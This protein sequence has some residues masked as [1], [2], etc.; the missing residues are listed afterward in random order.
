MPQMAL[1]RVWLP[2]PN[3]SSRG[4]TK[5]RL[6]VLHTTE[7][8]Q[9]FR[10]LGN[11]FGKNVGASSNVGIDN[12]TAGRIGEYVSRANKAWTQCNA[13]PYC[14]AAEQCTP[15]GAAAGWSRSYWL[16]NQSVL[17]HNTAAWVAEEAKKFGIPLVALTSAQ[18]QSGKSGVTQHMN[19]GTFGCGHSDCG[20]GYPLDVVLEWAAKGSTGGT[21]GKPP[22]S[23]AV[24]AFPYPADHYLGQ[25]SASAKCHSGCF[26]GT[27]KTNVTT[28]QKQMRSRGWTI[29]VDG[30]YGDQSESVCRSFQ[31]E[32]GLQADGYVGPSTWAK[33][34]S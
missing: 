11:Y 24:P 34:W 2:S 20:P 25:S 8:A 13:N 1:S 30:C 14:V 23:S 31:K 7:G 19:L 33:S 18:A 4:G 32:K 9:D 22:T 12:K 28:W 10:S 29:G 27:D 16:N 5:V 21:G 15:A 3:Y 17:L 26:G 6:I